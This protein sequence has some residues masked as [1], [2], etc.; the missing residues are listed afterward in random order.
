MDTDG[1]THSFLLPLD[2]DV[3]NLIDIR[4]VRLDQ[5]SNAPKP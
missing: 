2:C 5:N 1:Q 3:V 4:I